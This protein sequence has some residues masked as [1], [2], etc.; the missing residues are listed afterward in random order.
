MPVGPNDPASAFPA[1]PSEYVAIQLPAHADSPQQPLRVAADDDV[2]LLQYQA[3]YL[4]AGSVGGDLTLSSGD[5]N[6]TLQATASAD[7][8]DTGTAAV[9]ATGGNGSAILQVTNGTSTIR[10]GNG[11]NGFEAVAGD[12][13]VYAQVSAPDAQVGSNSQALIV[14]R[15]GLPMVSI[16]G[17]GDIRVHSGDAGLILTSPGGAMYRLGVDDDGVLGCALV[18]PGSE[19]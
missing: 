7:D 14:A 10:S 3:Y 15:G 19:G 11:A 12:D 17:N 16:Y 5:E 1:P 2:A 6:Y 9:W 4:G 18:S 13:S 8:E